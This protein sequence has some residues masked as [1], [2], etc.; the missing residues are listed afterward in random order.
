M[1][2]WLRAT[3][4]IAR[5]DFEFDSN[6]NREICCQHRQTGLSLHTCLKIT[7]C[8]MYIH[9][10]IEKMADTAKHRNTNNSANNGRKSKNEIIRSTLGMYLKQRNY[11]VSLI[12]SKNWCL[13]YQ[14]CCK[15]KS[16]SKWFLLSN[17]KNSEK[18]RKSDLALLQSNKQLE[19]GSML[20]DD[21][22]KVNSF[23]Y[24]NVLCLNKD[25]N[26]VEQFSK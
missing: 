13:L 4:C 3:S 17:L 24:S 25:S 8:M 10:Y 7:I 11:S 19:F 21:V 20:D 15:T 5:L 14:G 16:M 12:H 1:F 18:F 9:K 23:L 22:S 2:F 26:V 6:T